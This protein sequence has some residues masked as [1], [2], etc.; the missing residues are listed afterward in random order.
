MGDYLF[1]VRALFD[2]VEDTLQSHPGQGFALL[3]AWQRVI[4]IVSIS[5]INNDDYQYLQIHQESSQLPA[6][7][8]SRPR[9]VSFIELPGRIPRSPGV[10]VDVLRRMQIMMISFCLH[11]RRRTPSPNSTVPP[12][13]ILSDFLRRRRRRRPRPE[14][15][16][17]KGHR[18]KKSKAYL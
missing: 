15:A 3:I 10:G 4:K 16:R 11:H 6:H 5:I 14:N 7:R 8:A 18:G 9:M 12:R 1:Y 13:V 17:I 2:V